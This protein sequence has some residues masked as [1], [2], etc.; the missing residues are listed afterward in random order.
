MRAAVVVVERHDI[1]HKFEVPALLIAALIFFPICSSID[2]IT[3]IQSVGDGE[4]LISAGENFGRAQFHLGV[5][6]HGTV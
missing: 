4:T 2:T 3:S 6:S 5:V 1:L